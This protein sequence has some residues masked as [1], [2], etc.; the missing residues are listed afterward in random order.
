MGDR[1]RLS[2]NEMS[3][4]RLPVRSTFRERSRELSIG[5]EREREARKRLTYAREREG[6]DGL[7]SRESVVADGGMKRSFQRAEP[8]SSKATSSS[9]GALGGSRAAVTWPIVPR[10]GANRHVPLDA[11]APP[12]PRHL[13]CCDLATPIVVVTS[14]TGGDLWNWD[15]GP[16]PSTPAPRPARA[17]SSLGLDGRGSLHGLLGLP[18]PPHLPRVL[19]VLCVR[20]LACR[21]L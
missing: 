18:P 15:V 19:S 17:K 2:A 4:L 20:L 6:L 14:S 5:K 12:Q 8:A 11:L 16:S 7:I 9:G 3:L 1:A 10:R 21:R 13:G